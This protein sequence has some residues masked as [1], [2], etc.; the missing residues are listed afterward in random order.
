METELFFSGYCR[1]T[2]KSRLVTLLLENRELLDVD[3]CYV[4]CP[5]KQSCPIARQIDERTDT[6][7]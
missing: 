1:A 3:C 4:N 2:D 6:N 5:H 7:G